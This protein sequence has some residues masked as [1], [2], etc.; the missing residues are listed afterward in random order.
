MKG[1]PT[2]RSEFADPL[3]EWFVNELRHPVGSLDAPRAPP[4]RPMQFDTPEPSSPHRR[5]WALQAAAIVVVL[6]AGLVLLATRTVD[7]PPAAPGSSVVPPAE[8]LAALCADYGLAAPSLALDA[9][10]D[11]VAAA[12]T[13]VERRLG[14]AQARLTAAATDGVDLGDQ[15][16]LLA[17]A[18]DAAGRL[19]TIAATGERAAIDEAVR[20]LDLLVLAWG[21]SLSTIAGPAC[22]GLP[23]LREVR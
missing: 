12:A 14:A 19:R 11:E 7:A 8:A 1:D 23:T 21:R 17:E 2:P 5:W 13:D 18:L 6:V 22:T 20:N 3:R 15:R 4:P 16:R 9:S 10:P